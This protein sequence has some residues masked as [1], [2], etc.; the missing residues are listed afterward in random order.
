VIRTER[1]GPVPTLLL[2]RAGRRN[3]IDRDLDTGRAF[4]LGCASPGAA[5]ER[6]A[7]FAGEARRHRSAT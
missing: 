3:A 1:E 5:I 4:E 2:D 7:Q 6:A